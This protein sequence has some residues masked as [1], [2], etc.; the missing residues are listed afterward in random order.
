[1]GVDLTLVVAVVAQGIKDLRQTQMRQA[2]GDL[3][4]GDAP[5]P[6]LDDCR[7]VVG[8]PRMIGSPPR[9]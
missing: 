8:V 4:G 9:I 2:I 1:V 7:T 3:F 5:T 6:S